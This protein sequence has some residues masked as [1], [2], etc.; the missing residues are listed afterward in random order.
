MQ[1]IEVLEIVVNS[2]NYFNSD[3]ITNESR[4]AFSG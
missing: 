1:G 3:F 4:T 2:R